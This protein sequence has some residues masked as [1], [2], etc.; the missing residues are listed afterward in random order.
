MV[1]KGGP[2]TVALAAVVWARSPTG[3]MWPY[4]VATLYM[5]FTVHNHQHQLRTRR[6]GAF[7]KL[8]M[9]SLHVAITFITSVSLALAI[10][11]NLIIDTDLFSD[12]E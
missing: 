7:T 3:P 6:F 2:E 5:P 4:P 8:R 11:K 10:R 9:K 12:V 1:D